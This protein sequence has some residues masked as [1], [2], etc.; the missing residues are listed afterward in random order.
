MGQRDTQPVFSPQEEREREEKRLAE[1]MEENNH[2]IVEAQRKLVCTGS[3]CVCMCVWDMHF[4]PLASRQLLA[5]CVCVCVCVCVC[6]C[7]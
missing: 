3:S 1:I 2:K 4:P 5:I 7:A 6:E